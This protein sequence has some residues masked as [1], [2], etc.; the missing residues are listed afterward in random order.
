[1]ILK[2]IIF[3]MDLVIDIVIFRNRDIYVLLGGWV[4]YSKY[5][6]GY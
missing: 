5:I 3:F 1:M 6:N 4:Y 2:C